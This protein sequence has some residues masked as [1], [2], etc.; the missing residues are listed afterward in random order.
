M[1]ARTCFGIGDSG[2]DES[3]V[4][5]YPEERNREVFWKGVKADAMYLL[6]LL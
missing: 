3:T 4:K 1:G 5:S 6:I 2:F